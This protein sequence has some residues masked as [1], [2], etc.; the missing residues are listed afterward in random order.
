[1]QRLRAPAGRDRLPDG[2]YSAA[3][4]FNV[5]ARTACRRLPRY[6]IERS[7]GQ[8]MRKTL[9]TVTLAIFLSWTGMLAHAQ[10]PPQQQELA[11]TTKLNLSLEQR[12]TIREFIKDLKSEATTRDVQAAVGEAIPQDI[13]PRPMP[14]VVGQKVPQVK[15]HRFFVTGQQIVIVDP[16]D[17]KVAEVIKL[18]DN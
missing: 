2:N 10:T 12:H 16:K 5:N 8:K 4:K 11:P 13:D 18:T 6:F 3:R 9:K 17:N 15:T 1:L 7:G 14:T